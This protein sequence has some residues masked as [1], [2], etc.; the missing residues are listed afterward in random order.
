MKAEHILQLLEKLELNDGGLQFSRGSTK[1]DGI[2]RIIL[3]GG[4][5]KENTGNF[6]DLAEIEVQG[7]IDQIIKIQNKLNNKLGQVYPKGLKEEVN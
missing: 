3:S 7:S 1:D 2:F 4:W 6:F 5:S